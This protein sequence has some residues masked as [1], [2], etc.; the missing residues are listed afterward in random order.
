MAYDVSDPRVAMLV[1]DLAKRSLSAIIDS[2]TLSLLDR[3]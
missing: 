3:P 1:R 2:G